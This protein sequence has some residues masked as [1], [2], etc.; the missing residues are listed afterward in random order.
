MSIDTSV[1]RVDGV[2]VSIDTSV[3]VSGQGSAWLSLSLAGRPPVSRGVVFRG[4]S[5]REVGGQRPTGAV[6]ASQD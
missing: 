4:V 1:G 5:G 6:T 2:R 3:Q